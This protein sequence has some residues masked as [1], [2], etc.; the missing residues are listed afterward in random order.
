MATKL[1]MSVVSRSVKQL[2]NHQYV[3]GSESIMHYMLCTSVYTHNL[4]ISE[5][6][7][8]QVLIVDTLHTLLFLAQG[9]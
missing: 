4:H 2:N 7:N 3:S 8:R 9:K 6:I 5:L 1:V